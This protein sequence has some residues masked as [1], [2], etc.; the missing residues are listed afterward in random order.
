MLKKGILKE[1]KKELKS[2]SG[3]KDKDFIPKGVFKTEEAEFYLDKVEKNLIEKMN[4]VHFEEYANGDGQEFID[5]TTPAKMKSL[6]SST[7]LTFNLLGNDSAIIKPNS[8]GIDSCDYSVQYEKKLETLIGTKKANLDA[9][10]LS[11]DKSSVVFCEMKMFEWLSKKTSSVSKSYQELKRYRNQEVF[12]E[13]SNLFKLYEESSL[14]NKLIPYRYDAPQ[15]LKHSLGIYNALKDAKNNSDHEFFGVRKVTLLN[16]VWEVCNVAVLGD[17][18]QVYSKI[19]DEEHT[20][21]QS[22]STLYQPIIDLFKNELNIDLQ[23]C[24]L[25]HQEFINIIDKTPAE[26]KYLQRYCI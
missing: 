25:T 24:Y 11:L 26:L 15:M 1:L 14:S 12:I 5:K 20:G 23:L 16:C 3:L 18:G 7:A 8:R 9:C 19:A 6:H 13:F 17:E 2:C 4:E 10:L 22:F 21:Y